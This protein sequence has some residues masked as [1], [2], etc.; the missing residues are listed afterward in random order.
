[1]RST[2]ACRMPPARNLSNKT[3]M[4]G[5]A[6][7]TATQKEVVFKVFKNDWINL[8]VDSVLPGEL[9]LHAYRLSL[10]LQANELQ[11]LR[12]QAKSTGK[13]K[14]E[15]HPLKSVNDTSAKKGHAHAPPLA[16][17]EVLPR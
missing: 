9:H 13:F 2:V 8:N 10:P 12:F 16:S 4:V 15:W 6:S 7:A 3:P 14:L 5:S 11:S 1:M 17:I